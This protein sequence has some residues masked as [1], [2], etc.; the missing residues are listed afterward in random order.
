M[1]QKSDFKRESG[2]SCQQAARGERGQI[3]PFVAILM[4]LFLCMCGFVIDIGRVYVSYE[5][6]VASTD[7]AALAGGQALGAANTSIAQV[8][9]AVTTYSSSSGGV[10]P[11][12]MMTNLAVSTSLG[13]MTGLSPDI[14]CYGAGSYNAV[15]V[16]QTASLP[17]TFAN[18]FGTSSVALSSTATA[19]MS[20]AAGLPYNV[21]I[22]VDTTS[23]MG[24]ADNGSTCTT[25]RLACALSG[26]ATLMGKLA[27]CPTGGSCSI[28]N[29][30]SSSAVDRVALFTF[31]GVTTATT[32]NVTT[33]P[34]SDPNTEKVYTFPSSTVSKTAATNPSLKLSNGTIVTMTYNITNGLGDA[35]GFVSDYRTADTATTLNAGSPLSIAIG[36]G[37]SGCAGLGSPGG[38]GTF[39]AGVIYAATDSLLAEQSANPTAQNVMI[40]ISDG[41]ASSAESQMA[42]GSGAPGSD[43]GTGAVNASSTGTYPSWKNECHQAVTAAAAAAAQG[44]KVYAVAYGAESSG[45]S[46]DSPAITPCQ[47]MKD[48]ASNPGYFYSD[49]AQS[50]GGTDTTCAGSGASTTS[51]TA[52]FNDI[53]FSLGHGRLLP[54][55]APPGGSVTWT[56]E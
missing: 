11:V 54:N 41:D 47:T 29:N 40:I 32:A 26:V 24:D 4:T 9:T 46:T 53:Y 50:G 7:A 17:M 34:T 23:S 27:P 21:A 10:N 43:T 56:A 31:P 12:G 55:T 1:S 20:G 37:K 42:G 18:F 28:S 49:Y 35:N 33:C 14:P 5:Q 8:K 45:C 13:C 22:I 25:T 30:V 36:S 48:I 51:I 39:Y 44:I 2:L 52:I 15:K 19:S 16:V 38:A 3:F 6:L